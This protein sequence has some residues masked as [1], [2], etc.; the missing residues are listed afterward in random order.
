VQTKI[1]LRLPTWM[2]VAG[3]E[4]QPICEA[5]AI[6][7]EG[8]DAAEYT[9]ACVRSMLPLILANGVATAEEID[10]DTLAQRL[11]AT[12]EDELVITIGAFAS[13]WGR[14]P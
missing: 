1:G 8:G 3:L 4:P 6:V 13:V 14:K 9:A 5:S 10:I 2:R 11:L 7:L 12:G